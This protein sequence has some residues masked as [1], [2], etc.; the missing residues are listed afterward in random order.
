MQTIKYIRSLNQLENMHEHERR[1][2]GPVTERFAF[3]AND[4]Y[5]SLIDWSDPD[6]PIRRLIVPNHGELNPWGRLDASNESAYT[7]AP[8]LEHKY[9]FTA[10]LLVNDVCGGVCRFCFRKRL[11]MDHNDE[12]V[13]DVRPALDYIRAHTEINNVLLT[14]GDPLL[15]STRRLESIVA[16]LREMPHVQIIRIG[17]K[18]PAFNPYRILDDPALLQMIDRYATPERKIYAIVQFNHPRELTPQAIEALDRLQRAGA[19]TVNQTPLLQGINDDPAVLGELFN[20]L[21]YIGVPPYYVF[22]CRPVIGNRMFALP[23]EEGYEIFE[24]ARMQGSGLAKR[25]R[26]VMSHASGK[27]EVLGKTRHLIFFKFHRSADPDHKATTMV[28]RTQPDAYWF[29]DYTDKID[30]YQIENPF[31]SEE[32]LA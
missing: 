14:G 32:T 22:Q 13:R 24:Q 8:G 31:Y 16:Q 5:L 21:S 4:Y 28:Y 18:M 10:L 7:Q 30:E 1:R 19:V 26:F 20:Q 17:T 15:L 29:D 2:L 27:I 6:D 12:V 23:V 25:A 9:Q 3:R 11:F